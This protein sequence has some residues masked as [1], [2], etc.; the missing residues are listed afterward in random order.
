LIWPGKASCPAIDCCASSSCSADV[1]ERRHRQ[2]ESR[3]AREAA[4]RF[5]F[6]QHL[7]VLI[8]RGEHADVVP[9][10]RRGAQHRRTADVDVFD[11]LLERAVRLCHRALE[12][13][14]VQHQQIDRRDAQFGHH[15]VV[16]TAATEQAAVDLRMQGLDAAVHD[17]RE[18]GHVAHV[19]HHDTGVAQRFGAAAGGK[20]FNAGGD[21]PLAQLDQAG[22]VRHAE[23]GAA[24][25]CE[26]GGGHGDS[27][28]GQ[29]P[30]ISAL[31]AASR[32]S[33]EGTR[34]GVERA[35][36]REAVCYGSSSP[37]KN[38]K[39]V[40]A[41]EEA[42][43]KRSTTFAS[44]DALA[45]LQQP[46]CGQLLAQRGSVDAERAGGATLVAVVE[47]QHFAQQGRFDFPQNHGVQALGAFG[48]ADIGQIAA[49]GAGY[50]FAQRT[51]VIRVAIACMRDH[52]LAI[53]LRT[54]TQ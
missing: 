4:V 41:S 43:F 49:H 54:V 52:V 44:C 36:K 25:R 19:A 30:I 16:G 11:R 29:P 12:R 9:V 15:R 48:I 31:G 21:E 6:G 42:I 22:L 23:Q 38:R 32:K 33:P 28:A 27:W 10:F 46:V 18:A 45:P 2:L 50:A 8:G 53:A 26:S 17:F 39:V 40:C 34:R 24:N 5:D 47:R 13:I 35:N 7:S 37:A 51:D 14:Q 3:R 1:V 20:Q